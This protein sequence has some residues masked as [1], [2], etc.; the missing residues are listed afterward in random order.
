MSVQIYFRTKNII[1]D[2][3]ENDMVTAKESTI[4][5]IEQILNI[6]VEA[7]EEINHNDYIK[8]YIKRVPSKEE[9]K[10][11]EGYQSLLKTLNHIKDK[12]SNF[13]NVFIGLDNVNHI[14]SDSE[15]QPPEG[16]DTKSRSWYVGARQ[17]NGIAIT[18]PYIDSGT[19]LLVI[20]V[21]TPIN[22][23]DGNLIGVA[24][25][26]ISIDDISKIMGSYK[27]KDSGYAI[28]IDNTG[29][30]L[31]HPNEELIM[32]DSIEEI[33]GDLS[34]VGRKMLSKESGTEAITVDGSEYYIS[35]SPIPLSDWAV[36]LLVPVTEA[37]SE[38]YSFRTIFITII[39]IALAFQSLVIFILVK[40]ILKHIP[41]LLDAFR[42]AEEGD[43]TV[44][45]NTKVRDEIGLLSD[46]F[47]K[48]VESQ[49]NIINNVVDSIENIVNVFDNIKNNM[50]DLN[51][52]IE[53]VSATTEEIAAGMEETS[54]SMEE[55]NA[56]SNEITEIL[57][58]I[59]QKAEEGVISAKDIYNRALEVKKEAIESK[60]NVN[61]IYDVS[62]NKLKEAIEE[63][64]TIEQINVLSESI[65]AIT[66]QTNLLAL[67]AA[68]EAA[69]AGEAGKGFAV[70][71]DEIRKL[72]EESKNAV[73]KIQKITENVLQSVNKLVMSSNEVLDLV[74][75][76]VI[77]DYE[78]LVDTSGQYSNDAT[79]FEHLVSDFSSSFSTL[80]DMVM[81]MIKAIE[82]VSMS[83]NQET[84]AISNIAERSTNII[85]KTN[86][87][88]NEMK[89]AQEKIDDLMNVI[90]KF[91]LK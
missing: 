83:T 31:Y 63:S 20:T 10:T 14:I 80:K 24:A 21:A 1:V 73:A 36:A 86:D 77:K 17:N 85:E 41:V 54:A 71:A 35:Y 79:Y 7:V 5:D 44:R 12:D 15:F 91:K 25:V 74:D 49:K 9:A 57:D 81:N 58:D 50:D 42:M 66:E 11:T 82:E 78:I 19:D 43:L 84:E 61:D 6:A 89:D 8:E 52:N 53:D 72:A 64:K 40:G 13:L 88:I 26:D 87:V 75:K 45:A 67:N 46:G 70:V 39:I 48:M 23:S 2:A 4:N 69:R 30:F 37:H 3:I 27:Y 62:Q 47:N 65:L 28:L 34:A 33:Q 56:T 32:R 68:I 60:K 76:K 18:E 38:L 22:D 55:M 29:R 16:Y 90:S 51:K 59:A